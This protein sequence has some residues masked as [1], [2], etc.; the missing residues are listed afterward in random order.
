MGVGVGVGGGVGGGG[1]QPTCGI[2]GALPCDT[3]KPPI[4]AFST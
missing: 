4:Y 3:V 2:Q 1:C